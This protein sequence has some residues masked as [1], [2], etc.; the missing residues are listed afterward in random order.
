M[1]NVP[2]ANL[3][4]AILGIVAILEASLKV[5]VYVLKFII[6]AIKRLYKLLRGR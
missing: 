2:S 5:I 4:L 3:S 1:S 6:N